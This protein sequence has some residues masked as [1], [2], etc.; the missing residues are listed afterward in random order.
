MNDELSRAEAQAQVV[1]TLKARPETPKAP[2]SRCRAQLM[3]MRTTQAAGD[4]LA[5]RSAYATVGGV[6]PK[7]SLRLDRS[8]HD[9]GKRDERR[10]DRRFR[11]RL[12]NREARAVAAGENLRRV[13]KANGATRRGGGGDPIGL[14]VKRGKSPVEEGQKSSAAARGAGARG[15]KP[16]IARV[17]V[18]AD[19]QF[20]ATVAINDSGTY[21]PVL[22]RRPT[23]A[24]KNLRPADTFGRHQPVPEPLRD[25][26]QAEA[27]RSRVIDAVRV[28]ANDV[29]FQRSTTPGDSVEA[30]TRIPTTSI[31]AREL[32]Y[33]TID[34]PRSDV[35]V[36]SFPDAGRQH[37][38]L[39]RRERP[40]ERGSSSC[41]SR[42]PP[43]K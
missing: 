25:R 31:R 22:T 43:A 18:Y 38:R 26:A 24:A 16:R 15:E 40:L 14:R 4:P 19:G 12:A 13:L 42:S 1:E 36:L 29:D 34:R 3:L 23:D 6:A 30:S 10:E 27:C 7:R 17:S 5:S 41:A 2:S 35:Q 20:K 28:F 37:G 11:R 32:L 21:A 8:A 33:A 39:L 9:S